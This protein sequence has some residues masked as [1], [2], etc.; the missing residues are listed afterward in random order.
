MVTCTGGWA[1]RA[2]P[3]PPGG[4]KGVELSVTTTKTR[5]SP[6]E[7]GKIHSGELAAGSFMGRPHSSC[8]AVT[9]VEESALRSAAA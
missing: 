3:S 7:G 4:M 5:G 2:G 1:S 9:G 8:P 6:R